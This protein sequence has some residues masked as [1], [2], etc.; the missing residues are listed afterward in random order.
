MGPADSG[1]PSKFKVIWS[2][3]QAQTAVFDG[4]LYVTEPWRLDRTSARGFKVWSAQ[5][6]VGIEAALVRQLYVDGVR[7]DR[8]RSNASTAGFP[9]GA[10]ATKD[11]FN[12][13]AS[14]A[15]LNWANASAVE[16]VSDHTWVQHRCPVVGIDAIVAPPSPPPTPPAPPATCTWGTPVRGRSPGSS[17]K[18]FNAPS[19]GMC[20]SACCAALPMC[21]SILF[22]GPGQT[23]YLLNRKFESNFSS[24]TGMLADLNCSQGPQVCAPPPPP[25]VH[26]TQVRIAQP[27]YSVATRP[28]ALALSTQ[29][30]SFFEN[31]GQFTRT[32]QF[33]IN[34]T[35]NQIEVSTDVA[36]TKAVFGV[37]QTLLLAAGVHDVEY[38]NLTFAHSGWSEPSAVGMVER[39]GGVLNNLAGGPQYM[40]PAAVT[41]A[42]ASS[43]TFSGCT[44]TQLGAWGLRL[45]NASQGIVVS[46]NIFE[47][48]SGGGICVGN[49]NDTK[50]T[51]PQYQMANISIEDNT[52]TDLGQEYKGSTGVHSFCMRG[53]SISHNRIRGVSY[54]GLSYN[55]PNPQGP[56][57]GPPHGDGNSS[58]G[59]S[60]DNVVSGNDVSEY[61]RYMKDGGGIHTIGRS[62]NTTVT[63][64]Y[65][66]DVA[67]GGLCGTNPCHSTVSQSSIYIDNWSAGYSITE[68]VVVNTSNTLNGW[69]FFQYFSGKA[70]HGQAHDCTAANNTICNTGPVPTPR[71]PW[72]E[73]NGPNVSNTVNMTAQATRFNGDCLPVLP[74]A[75]AQVVREAGPR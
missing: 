12:V 28:G 69:L 9:T 3:E 49:L 41:V 53:S 21:E 8:T 16:L 15:D 74:S 17:Y 40:V 10:V 14:I 27:C 44:F 52:L 38:H 45:A 4:G 25:P 62:T 56:T 70:S 23:C 32:G 1:V 71:D 36:P 54:S 35:T 46:R 47:D 34:V 24:G 30:V 2:S 26:R 7:F 75:A 43:V 64:N 59:Y 51:Q 66:H 5:L 63:R 48:L 19:W 42:N 39:Y 60:R 37:K 61:M 72:D 22:Y 33:Y 57:F 29:T 58:T 11:G 68:N 31:T 18:Q 50:E 6:P 13:T 67:S 55:W 73:V 65:F 20:Q